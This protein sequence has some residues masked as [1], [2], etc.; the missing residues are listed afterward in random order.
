MSQPIQRAIL[1]VTDKT[2]LA[3]FARNLSGMGVE[4][5]ST[6][7]TAKLLRQQAVQGTRHQRDLQVDINLQAHPARQGDVEVCRQRPA[8]TGHATRHGTER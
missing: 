7:G 1:S 5:I 2:G 4:L 3:E 6:G 8:G